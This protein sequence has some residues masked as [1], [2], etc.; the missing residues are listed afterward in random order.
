MLTLAAALLLSPVS[1]PVELPSSPAPLHGT[2]LTPEGQTRAVAVILPGS[3]PTDRDGDSPQ[4][5]IRAA[6]YRLQAEG[7]AERGVATIRIDKRGIGESAAAGG[8]EADL[9]F[10][11]NID[12]ARAWAAEATAKTGR[13]CAWLIGHSEGALV[14]LATVAKGDDKVC[15]LVL[16]SGAGR[17]A[18]VVLREQLAAGLP[19]P[20][21]TRAYDILTEL[22]AGRTVANPPPELAAMFRPSVQPYLISWL[23]LD[24]AKLAAAYDGPIFIGQGTTDIQ[25][26]VA[27]AEALKTAQ[28]RAQLA[29]W[30]GVN[31][32]LKVAP[33]ER[34]AN[35]ATYMDP[36]LPLA[37]GVVQAVADFVLR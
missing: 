10:T 7:L 21:K 26:M 9:R 6:T 30:D 17:P 32:V 27:D 13:P 22:E 5:G 15:G 34:A 19:E 29:I 23:A 35:I 4:F 18:G 36:A 33:A 8:A 1:T 3:G 37:P 12:D 11:T 24:P 16:L 31:H 2:L 25:V 20:L 14:A 28:P